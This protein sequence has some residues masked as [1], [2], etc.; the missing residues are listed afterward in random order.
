M[1]SIIRAHC[2]YKIFPISLQVFYHLCDF[3]KLIVVLQIFHKKLLDLEC[4]SRVEHT[5]VRGIVYDDNFI[6]I[7]ESQLLL[8]ILH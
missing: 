5:Y 2:L 3:I 1:F 7:L 8:D 6:H 4:V